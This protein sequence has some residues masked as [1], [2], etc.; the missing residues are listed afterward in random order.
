MILGI[1]FSIMV[2][3]TVTFVLKKPKQDLQ[4]TNHQHRLRVG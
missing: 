1:V 4:I 3:A 2:G